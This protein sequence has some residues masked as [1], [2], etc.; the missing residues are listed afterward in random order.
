MVN[1]NLYLVIKSS[2]FPLQILPLAGALSTSLSNCTCT[3]GGH[4]PLLD[5]NA[6]NPY[7]FF[8]QANVDDSEVGFPVSFAR[9]TSTSNLLSNVV[10]SRDVQ[11]LSDTLTY[12]PQ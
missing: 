8:L 12:V 10:P 4:I 6:G 9:R 7:L 11:V 1:N 3:C 5:G 2:S